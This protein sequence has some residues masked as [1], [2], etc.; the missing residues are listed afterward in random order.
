MIRR[1]TSLV[2]PV[3]IR[4]LL[5]TMIASSGLVAVSGCGYRIVRRDDLRV[6]KLTADSAAMVTL[7]H[8]IVTLQMKCHADSVRAATDRA[9]LEK[10]IADHPVAAPVTDSTLKARDAEIATLKDQLTKANA[11]LDRIKRRLANPRS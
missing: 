6:Q 2:P 11:E 9:A 10:S 5:A 3:P 7:Q 1:S 8:Q 4:V